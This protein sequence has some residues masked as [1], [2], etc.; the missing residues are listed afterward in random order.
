MW[1]RHS[2]KPSQWHEN[3]NRKGKSRSE[4]KERKSMSSSPAPALKKNVQTQPFPYADAIVIASV[5]MTPESETVPSD[6]TDQ[7]H[8]QEIHKARHEGETRA[9]QAY[10]IELERVRG[11][12]RTALLK[13]EKD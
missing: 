8:E 4:Q 12:L 3:W 6:L 11:S 5:Q 7:R 9:R 13:F 1:L 2:K 10:E